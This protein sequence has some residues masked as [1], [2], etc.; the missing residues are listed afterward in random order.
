MTRLFGKYGRKSEITQTITFLCPMCNKD[1]PKEEQELC[2]KTHVII[3]DRGY[4]V[5]DNIDK[6]VI[7]TK[8]KNRMDVV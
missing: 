7:C 4:H 3:T 8:C 6:I 2:I 1:K 5:Y